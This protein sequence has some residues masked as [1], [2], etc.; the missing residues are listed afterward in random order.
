MTPVAGRVGSQWWNVYHSVELGSR[1]SHHR[2]FSFVT[3]HR[4][5]FGNFGV[6]WAGPRFLHK[7]TKIDVSVQ[8]FSKFAY[9][10]IHFVPVHVFFI[11]ESIKSTWEIPENEWISTRSLNMCMITQPRDLA[12]YFP[13]QTPCSHIPQAP[14]AAKLSWIVLQPGH[15]TS[16][17]RWSFDIVFMVLSN[18]SS[19]KP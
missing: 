7:W 1:G 18:G 2:R 3:L 8:N 19:K 4:R 13:P 16:S 17:D 9:I 10:L 12:F 14:R 11:N 6:R 15:L 5:I